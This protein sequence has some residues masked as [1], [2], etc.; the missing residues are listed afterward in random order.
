MF[1]GVGFEMQTLDESP[2]QLITELLL[3]TDCHLTDK[4]GGE[5][6]LF[7]NRTTQTVV[8][9][10][11]YDEADLVKH[12][13]GELPYQFRCSATWSDNTVRTHSAYS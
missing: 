13:N 11:I 5:I 9:M 1:K 8:A 4:S 6:M 10:E 3:N 7:N 2:G 12:P